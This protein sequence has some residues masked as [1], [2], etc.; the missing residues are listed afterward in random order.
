MHT[1]GRA[2]AHEHL[3]VGVNSS[4]QLCPIVVGDST[5]EARE[6]KDGRV[7]AEGV[8]LDRLR[9]GVLQVLRHRV[10]WESLAEICCVTMSA[11]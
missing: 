7:L 9:H 1:L 10:V 6:A 11:G 3:T 4:T 2:L 8:G 5:A